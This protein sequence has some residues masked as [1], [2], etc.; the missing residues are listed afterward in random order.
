M[1]FGRIVYVMGP[2]GAGK[3][4]L[5]DYARYRLDGSRPILFAHRYITRPLGKDG[6]NYI[7]LSHAEFALR[8][9]HGLFACDWQAYGF[10]YGIGVEIRAWLKAG[11]IV[12]IDGSRGH[13]TAHRLDIAPVVP[14]LV[15]AKRDVLRRRLAE[16]ERDD[17]ASIEARLRRAEQFAPADLAI[18][19]IDNS[20]AIE[21]AGEA[22]LAVLADQLP[23][24]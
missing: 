24:S 17:A 12:V 5:I 1:A 18:A 10:D 8:Q 20:G 7:A 4:R 15:T 21:R 23:P 13:F 6:E 19:T 2:S 14:V 9:S 16:R 11:L 3:T 22:F